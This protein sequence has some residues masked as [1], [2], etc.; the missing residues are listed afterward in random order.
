MTCMTCT[1]CMLYTWFTRGLHDFLRTTLLNRLQLQSQCKGDLRD[2]HWTWN[3]GL[4]LR[5]WLAR[6]CKRCLI[7]LT[8]HWVF[9]QSKM[10]KAWKAM[11]F[12]CSDLAGERDC[13][14]DHRC[15][16]WRDW[17]WHTINGSGSHKQLR[18]GLSLGMGG[19]LFGLY[20]WHF[21]SRPGNHY[22]RCTLAAGVEIWIECNPSILLDPSIDHKW[23]QKMNVLWKWGI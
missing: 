16:W 8:F 12:G 5:W 9:L 14:Q 7:S 20:S 1:V 19:S 17:S 10:S 13:P 11:W 18:P 21:P 4:A 15:W 22:A 2:Q 3:L 23:L 6:L